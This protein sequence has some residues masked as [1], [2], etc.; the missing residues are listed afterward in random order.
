M[1]KVFPKLAGLTQGRKDF[2]QTSPDMKDQE[3]RGGWLG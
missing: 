1:D 2:S 3:A